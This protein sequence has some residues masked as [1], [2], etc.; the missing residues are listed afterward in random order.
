MMRVACDMTRVACDMMRVACDMT[1]V[2]CDM[3]RVACDMMRVACDMTRVACDMMRV[4]CDMT[5]VACDMMRVACDMTRVACDM[6]RRVGAATFT[7]SFKAF[8]VRGMLAMQAGVHEHVG[9]GTSGAQASVRRLG[10]E[11]AAAGLWGNLANMSTAARLLDEVLR[12]P[13]ER[14]PGWRAA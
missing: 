4:A 5:R 11:W 2:A 13:N 1:R 7:R 8:D 12:L 3:M 6:M 10:R 14:V 9:G